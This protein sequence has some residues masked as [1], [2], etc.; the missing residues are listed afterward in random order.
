M[1]SKI[2]LCISAKQ[3][4]V[5]V[6][7]LERFVSC[8][9]YTNDE[10]GHAKFRL[11]LTRYHNSPVHLIID[12][13][14]E[15]YRTE[16]M[17]HSSGKI[18]NEML[19]R[20]LTQLYRST[21]YRT[22][23][24]VGREKDKR[25]D[26]RILMMAL[27]NADL[28]APWIAMLEEFEA[29]LAGAYMLPM[30]SQLLVK[31]LKLKQPNLLL[32]TQ[33][34]A[35][36]RQTYFAD[37]QARL[38]RITPVSGMSESQIEKLYLSET[39]KT[40]LYMISLR[41]ITRETPIH[42]VFPTINT[43]T[44][45][46]AKQLEDNHGITT[47]IVPPEK[48]AKKLGVSTDLLSRYPDL[49]HMHLLAK[50]TVS[51]NLL[52]EPQIKNYR[53]LQIK[54]GLNSASIAA[55]FIAT[56]LAINSLINTV[57]IKQQITDAVQQ[58]QAQ[59]ALYTRISRDF[60]KTPIPGSDLKIAVEL[61]QKFDALNTTPQRFMQVLSEALN[62]QPELLIHRLR[63]KQTEDAKFSDDI[64]GKT[65]AKAPANGLPD[66]PPP[67]PPSGLYEIGF[68][69]GEIEHFSGDYRAALESVE[70]FA[71]TLKQNKKV[72]KVSITLQPFNTSSKASLQG[73]TLDQQSLQKETALFQL[74][75]FLKPETKAIPSQIGQNPQ[76]KS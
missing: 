11:F 42:L 60:P 15:D 73:S 36:L 27:T 32:M 14:E 67:L 22:A 35:G 17:P 19:H 68:V 69:D 6:W 48:L 4:T 20:K 30:V 28:V 5:G 74:K 58:T 76:V 10:A 40:R 62:K 59:E 7:R 39:E 49:L 72:A 61:A 56:L 70:L 23:Q 12:A 24:F 53:L 52:T 51:S 21:P 18:R 57:S 71:D 54:L 63:W 44:T 38:S 46:L 33:Q 75:V 43:I 65:Q 16:T 41:M 9:V 66:A 25:R 37:Q 34:S 64:P 3:A 31:A 29:P 55:V 45:D 8:N 26:D 13:V 1:L 2:I 50:G 47:E